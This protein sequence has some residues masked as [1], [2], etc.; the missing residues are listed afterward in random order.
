M[1]RTWSGDVEAS[2]SLSSLPSGALRLAGVTD[3]FSVSERS[4]S[5]LHTHFSL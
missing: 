2:L 5:S 1:R 3:T 4:R